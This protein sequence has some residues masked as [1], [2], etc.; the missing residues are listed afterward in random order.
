MR[1]ESEQEPRSQPFLVTHT[2]SS[3]HVVE[4]LVWCQELLLHVCAAEVPHVVEAFV[5]N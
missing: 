5:T 3:R 1:G 2:E 4:A